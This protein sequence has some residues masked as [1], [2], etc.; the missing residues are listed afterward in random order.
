MK[1]E[2]MSLSTNERISF[3]ISLTTMLSAGITLIDALDSLLEDNKGQYKQIVQTIKDDVSQGKRLYVA[4]SRFPLVFDKV[5]VNVI[6]AA[7]EA[8]TLETTLLQIKE[9]LEKEAEFND[10]IKS[11]LTYPIFILVV[12][13]GIMTM[14]LT[15]VIPK[16]AEVFKRLRVTLPLPTK[17]M[18]FLSD[19]V[20]KNT[21]PFLIGTI[22]VIVG[23]LIIFKTQKKLLS[24]ILS[25]LPLIS[26]LIKKIDLVRFTRNLAMLLN[27]GIMII[28]ALDICQELVINKKVVEMIA[29]SKTSI[30]S[31]KRFAEGLRTKKPVMPN[32]IIR[33]IESGEKSGSLPK[34]LLEASKYT[35][36]E[37][38]K[39]L[40]T[41]I[42]LLEPVMLVFVGVLVGAMMISIIAPIYGLIGQVGAR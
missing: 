34:A 9:N 36:Y 42:T 15:F 18:I 10:K 27:S 8:G 29:S 13:A 16:I 38:S 23:T 28:S 7:E 3:I 24:N 30:L 12:L 21:I 14:M 20:T 33:I 35:D 22:I 32:I 4:F 11:A 19:L 25:S 5:T 37:V 6:K 39:I 17:I 31:G 2:K 1:I 41:V 26:E 40:K